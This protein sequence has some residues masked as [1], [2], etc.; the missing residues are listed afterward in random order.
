MRAYSHWELAQYLVSFRLPSCTAAERDAFL[1]GSIEPD[2]N[3]TTYLKGLLHGSGVHG[4][5]YEQV[6]PRIDR[7]LHELTDKGSVHLLDWYRIGKLTHF[8]ADAFTY[9]HNSCF[10]GDLRAHMKYERQLAVRFRWALYDTVSAQTPPADCGSLFR[11]IQQ[12]H[13]QYLQN[14]MGVD[15]DARFIRSTV[16]AVVAVLTDDVAPIYT[17]AQLTGGAS[18]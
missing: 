14:P 16:C 5:N 17:P 3:C 8:I 6:L 2:L 15:N 12:Q 4:H 10:P 13:E 18:L 7:L 9:P 11:W 1:F